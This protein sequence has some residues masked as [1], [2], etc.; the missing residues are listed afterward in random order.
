M[1]RN[2]AQ[3]GMGNAYTILKAIWEDR[4][5]SKMEDSNGSLDR[6]RWVVGWNFLAQNAF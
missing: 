6:E 1:A 3:T 5:R 4:P 2:V